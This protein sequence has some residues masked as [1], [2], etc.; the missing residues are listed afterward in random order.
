M[1]NSIENGVTYWHKELSN[2][3]KSPFTAIGEGSVIHAGVHIHDY[4]IIGKRCKIEAQA[5]LPNGVVLKDDVFVGPLVCFT[6]DPTFK[7][8]DGEFVPCGT[9]VKRGAKIG[10]NATIR[11]GVTIG[12]DAII[13]CGSVIL[14]DVPAGEVWAG[15]PAKFIKKVCTKK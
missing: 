5:F 1:I 14:H 3:S 12:E 6:N 4:V 10:A 7:N 11:A 2:I 15:N 9:T 8:M 13:G